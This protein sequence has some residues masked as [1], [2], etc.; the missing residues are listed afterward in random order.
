MFIIPHKDKVDH[1]MY[2]FFGSVSLLYIGAD[3]TI[4]IFLAFVAAVAKELYDGV[5]NTLRE[6]TLDLLAGMTGTFAA[7][8]M[9]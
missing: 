2:W 1:F 4:T 6:H 9:F 3:P 7:V 8:L 5:N